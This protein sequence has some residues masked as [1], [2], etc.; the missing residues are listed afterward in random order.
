VCVCAH[1]CTCVCV[2]LLLWDCDDRTYSYYIEVSYDQRNWVKVVDKT[3]EKCR[4]WQLVK[5]TPQPVTFI[6]IVGTHNTANE[7]GG[8]KTWFPVVLCV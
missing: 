4:S 6:R 5:F 7:V 8:V 2:R 1:L 3:K